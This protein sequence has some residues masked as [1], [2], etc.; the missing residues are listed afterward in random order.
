MREPRSHDEQ[1][2]VAPRSRRRL[3]AVTKLVV[4]LG[5][6]G[7]LGARIVQRDGVDVLAERLGALDPSWI[8]VAIALHAVAVF[9]GV[10]RWRLLMRAAGVELSL[11]FCVRSFLIGRFVGAFTPSTAGL[12]GWRM[13]EA[14][15][16]S[17]AM[18]RGA[19]AIVVEKLVGLVGMAIVCA[20]L[21]PFGGA[22][23]LGHGAIAIALALAGAAGLGLALLRRP[24]WLEW[25]ADRLPRAVRGRA[26]KAVEALADTRLDAR[27]LVLAVGLGIA[28]HVALSS[29]FWATAGALDV[30]ASAWTLLA[31]GNAI[32]VAVLLPVSVGGVGVREGVAVVLLA[33][34][35]VASTDAALIA[36]LGYLTGQVPALAG[37]VLLAIKK[38]SAEPV[39]L[40]EQTLS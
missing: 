1:R 7:W 11:G 32:V 39:V 12:D 27:A 10:L 37:G 25:I 20:A 14:G 21:V 23:L 8:A 30:S 18:G 16:A 2:A 17:G 36:L 13:W 35:G 15:R 28:S 3:L 24:A 19:A 22:A 31:V 33:S 38:T 4:S 6:L 29:V 34:A 5:L 40:A 26:R 9:A